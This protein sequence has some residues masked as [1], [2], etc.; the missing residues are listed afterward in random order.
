MCM[1]LR[2]SSKLKLLLSSIAA[3]TAE[4]CE[5]LHVSGRLGGDQHMMQCWLY[6][7]GVNTCQGYMRLHAQFVWIDTNIV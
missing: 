3:H 6:C 2:T 5:W 1:P 4:M 7:A